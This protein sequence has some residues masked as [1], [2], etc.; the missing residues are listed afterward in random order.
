[1]TYRYVLRINPAR[2][3]PKPSNKL[4]IDH[5]IAAANSY[6]VKYLI[7]TL[8]NKD[9]GLCQE[10]QL[11]ITICSAVLN[12][13][14]V[15]CEEEE[16]MEGCKREEAE[17]RIGLFKSTLHRSLIWVGRIYGHISTLLC[18]VSQ[19]HFPSKT[20]DKVFF[21]RSKRSI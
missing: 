18:C 4:G 2:K 20:Q 6:N 11:K 5:K 14:L 7:S 8:L 12:M 19:A 13:N 1:L 9:Y 17:E 21:F 15:A 10:E 3:I 16:D